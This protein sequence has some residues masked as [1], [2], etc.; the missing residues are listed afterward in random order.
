MI[1]R[2]S[3][4]AV[5]GKAG[6]DLRAVRT[7]PHDAGSGAFGTLARLHLDYDRPHSPRTL[8]FKRSAP[9]NADRA[10]QFALHER[11]VSFYTEL[12]DRCGVRVPR[13]YFAGEAGLLLE[14]LGGSVVGDAQEGL[15]PDRL[16]TVARAAGGMHAR[17]WQNDALTQ[18]EWLPAHNAPVMTQIAGV[19]RDA[20]PGF[21]EVFGRHLPPGALDL[22]AAVADY[23][24][25]VLDSLAREPFTLVHGDMRAANIFFS[26]GDRGV[27][28]VDWQLCCRGKGVFDVAYLLAGSATVR[29]RRRYEFHILREWYDV[30]ADGRPGYTFRDAVNDYRRGLLACVGYAVAGVT[31]ARPHERERRVAI[32]QGVRTFTAAV[33]MEAASL[34]T[35]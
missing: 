14:D 11:E 18:L 22:G 8:V 21:A 25:S 26:D 33:E 6:G 17:W 28:F 1:T 16:R 34:L 29:V 12:G 5:L 35:A 19:V 32:L 20:W 30:A 7:A 3:V 31:L 13:C 4:A 24:E 23:Y 15:G 27:T 9:S 2:D 10:R